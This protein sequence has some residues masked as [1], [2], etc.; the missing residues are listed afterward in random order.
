[1]K[2]LFLDRDGVINY[3]EGYLFQ[4]EKLKFIPGIES[5]ITRAKL[6]DY[7]V[8]CITNQSGIARGFYSEHNFHQLMNEINRR[9]KLNCGY[10][11][12]D[13]YYCP[14][15]PDGEIKKFSIKCSC[16]KPMDG[17]IRKAIQKYKINVNESILVGDKI[18]DMLCG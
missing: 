18:S 17:M 9:L 16:R 12:D 5:L 14:H 6:K 1:M 4:K 10:C 15:H 11:L 3:D 7:L 8:I 2:A 13:Y